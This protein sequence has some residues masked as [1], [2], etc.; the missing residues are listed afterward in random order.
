MERGDGRVAWGNSEW[1]GVGEEGERSGEEES[2]RVR[3]G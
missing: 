3:E 2:E 1:E